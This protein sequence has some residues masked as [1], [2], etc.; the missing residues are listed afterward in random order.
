ME[1]TKNIDLLKPLFKKKRVVSQ[2]ITKLTVKLDY[3]YGL[4]QLRTFEYLTRRKEFSEGY[5]YHAEDRYQKKLEN[6]NK[7]FLSDYD[8]KLIEANTLLKERYWQLRANHEEFKLSNIENNEAVENNLKNLYKEYDIYKEELENELSKLD[9]TISSKY[10]NNEHQIKLDAI[11]EEFRSKLIK[12]IELDQKMLLKTYQKLLKHGKL[13][14]KLGLR[15][16]DNNMINEMILAHKEMV[17]INVNSYQD[18]QESRNYIMIGNYHALLSLR[19]YQKIEKIKFQITN[20]NDLLKSF[21]NE[22]N[23]LI[24][25]HEELKDTPI[26]EMQENQDIHIKINGLKMY[27]GG[28]KAVDDLNFDIKRGE[29]FSLIGPNGAGKTTV[30]NCITQFYKPT[31][32]EVYI[33]NK[34]GVTKRLNDYKVHDIINQ[35]IA[36]TFQNVELITELTVFENLLVGSHS[37]FQTNFLQ[38]MFKTPKARIEEK[39]LQMRAY[40]IL[41]RLNLT[42]YMFSY[43]QGLPY[44]TLKRVELARALMTNP[45]IIIL[46]EPAAGLNEVETKELAQLIKE[47][48]VEFELTIFLVEH[49]MSLVMD[50]SDR[51]CVISFGK[52]LA[53]GDPIEIQKNPI[54]QEAYLG[55]DHDE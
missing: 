38:H 14:N 30:F 18:L 31:D 24:V 10:P 3:Y 53:I 44:G 50:I 52:M 8:L 40:T 16:F 39:I 26:I 32:G 46:D 55:G 4:I 17:K 51:I 47:L 6:T 42:E 15:I 36:R 54:V 21:D 9:K 49:D 34:L 23:Q 35:G 2:N 1:K 22:L 28:L 33:N 27:F 12:K 43:P 29:I 5:Y 20:K 11:E 45:E 25:Q 37:L 41:K 48:N 19:N 13:I 7:D